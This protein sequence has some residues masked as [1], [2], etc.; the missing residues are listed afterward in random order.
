M[1]QDRSSG[2]KLLPKRGHT[3]RTRS[4][5]ARTARSIRL[6]FS[7]KSH[8]AA[9]CYRVRDGEIEFLLVRTHA[10]RWTF[11]KGAI[12]GDRTPAA[13]AAREAYEEA[14]VRGRVE[15]RAFDRYLHTKNGFF[16][17]RELPVAA[18][19]CRVSAED[20]PLE[21]HRDPTWFTPAKAK[22]RVRKLRKR[23][24]AAEMS[25]VIDRALR[26]ITTG[27]RK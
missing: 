23:K 12:D 20:R 19:L 7:S 2:G 26:R 10:G 14:G 25:R 5:A 8:V 21:A 6:L 18:H 1:G 17:E 15:A 24:Y 11:P 3:R 9:I 27:R 16:F 13:A 22:Q 4:R